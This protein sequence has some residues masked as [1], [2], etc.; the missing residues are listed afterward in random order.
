MKKGKVVLLISGALLVLILAALPIMVA[1]AQPAPAPAPSPTAKPAPAAT[2]APATPK[3]ATTP[4]ASPTAAPPTVIYTIKFP[5]MAAAG[6]GRAKAF[7]WWATELQ[8]RTNG[9]VK[10]ETYW[11]SSLMGAME[12]TPGVMKGIVQVASYYAAYHPDIAPLPGMALSPFVNRHSYKTAM[13]A[14][15]EWFST[16]EGVQAEFKKNNVRFLYPGLFAGQFIWSKVPIKTIADLKGLRVRTYG[17]FLALFKELGSGLVDVAVPEVYNALERGAVDVSTFPAD[18]A[19]G[20]KL[21]EVV[22]YV[23]AT[24]LGHNVGSPVVAN[25]DFWNKLPDDIKQI[26]DKLDLEM[27][28]KIVEIQLASDEVDIKYMKDK[29]V[30]FSTFSAADVDKLVE[31]TKTKVWAPYIADMEAKK[32]VPAGKSFKNYQDLYEKYRAKYN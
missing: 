4:P 3:P 10:V 21:E 13:Y 11:G 32:G 17:P 18:V 2:P 20:S 29:G 1:C 27:L 14:A 6:T 30:Q 16:D 9:R 22:K 12:Q 25:Q 15:N 23:V 24:N 7:D 28:D 26:M 5:D 8:K 31:I 19:R